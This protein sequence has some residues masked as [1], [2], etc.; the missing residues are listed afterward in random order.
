MTRT[1]VARTAAAVLCALAP[2]AAA[3]APVDVLM[4]TMTPQLSHRSA[5]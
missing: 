2:L 1:A 5:A 3:Q 4:S